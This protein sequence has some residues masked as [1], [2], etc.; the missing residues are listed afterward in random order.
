MF[1]FSSTL[2]SLSQFS[3][4][5]FVLISYA[6]T[7][8]I[9]YTKQTLNVRNIA[10][11][12]TSVQRKTVYILSFT[13]TKK[14]HPFQLHSTIC[15]LRM[16]IYHHIYDLT[17]LSIMKSKP[18]IAFNH[19]GWASAKLFTHL[20]VALLLN[21]YSFKCPHHDQLFSFFHL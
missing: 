7:S 21:L 16:H 1:Q 17:S 10:T 13:Q 15:K 20:V 2:S 9:E 12:M 5:F 6:S 4:M 11:T 18:M 3:D 14:L 19:V 8:I